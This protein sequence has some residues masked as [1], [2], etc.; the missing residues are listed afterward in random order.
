MRGNRGHFVQRAAP[1]LLSVL[2]AL[3]PSSMLAA[4]VGPRLARA[5]AAF[6]PLRAAPLPF[7]KPFLA[8]AGMGGFGRQVFAAAPSAPSGA[9]MM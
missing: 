2:V 9:R 8:A 4:S 1:L 5:A 7:A 3:H 6:V